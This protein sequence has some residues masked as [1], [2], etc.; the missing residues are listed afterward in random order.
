ME[1][2]PIWRTIRPAVHCSTIR[3]G[4]FHRVLV[5][6]YFL[7]RGRGHFQGDILGYVAPK[8]AYKK[9]SSQIDWWLS[10]WCG[11]WCKKNEL[12]RFIC[13]SFES[14]NR[15]KSDWISYY[16]HMIKF[17]QP[18]VWVDCRCYLL[19]SVTTLC[20]FKPRGC[21]QNVNAHCLWCCIA[22]MFQ[23]FEHFVWNLMWICTFN[24]QL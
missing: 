18:Y 11:L 13:S 3:L 23:I 24:M 19:H 12:I 8:S 1:T 7:L 16:D 6:P 9:R 15:S 17:A 20:E 10:L 4:G 22:T 21:L 14:E 5:W 2:W